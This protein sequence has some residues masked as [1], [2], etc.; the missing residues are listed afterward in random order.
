MRTSTEGDVVLAKLDDGEDLFPAILEI[1]ARHGFTSGMVLWGI[2]MLRDAELGYFTGAS[3]E[4]ETFREPQELLALHG[5]I[6]DDAEI[7][8]HLHVALAGRDHRV[9]GGHLF[10]ATVAVLNEIAVRPFR[11]IRLAR[12]LSPRSGLRELVLESA[13]RGG[14]RGTRRKQ[15]GTSRRRRTS[16]RRSSP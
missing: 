4:R 2:G 3:Y 5:S 6:A 13:R 9:V 11:E 14:P 8:L 10:R 7:P 1:A 16:G 12:A 15:R